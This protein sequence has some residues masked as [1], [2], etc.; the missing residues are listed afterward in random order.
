MGLINLCFEVEDTG[1][2]IPEEQLGHIFEEFEQVDSSRNRQF[3][4]TGLGLAI[5]TR[6]TA[7]MNGRIS[8]TSKLQQGSTFTISI[9]LPESQTKP[10][11]VE[12]SE[13]NLTGLRVLVVDDLE[14]NRRVLSERLC[15]WDVD[16]SLASSGADALTVL[17]AAESPFDLIIQDYQMPHMDGEELAKRIR[18][19]EGSRDTPLIILS[20]VDQ[21]IDNATRTEIGA[22]RLL[23]KPVRAQQ[24]RNTIT[25]SILTRPLDSDEPKAVA[26][27]NVPVE[28]ISVLVA[29]DNK[30]NQLIVKSMLKSASV[31]LTF[32]ENGL[33]ALKKFNEV[34]PNL[35][36]M[37]MSMPEMD[38][39]EATH[40][41]RDLESDN[42]IGHCPIVALTAN[43]M[44]EDQ[45]R[46]LGAGMDD[47][48]SKPI[49][50]K[51]L[52]DAVHRWG[53]QVSD[54]R[55]A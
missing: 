16:V 19:M 51:A 38:G 17:S 31:S 54:R 53:A 52:M 5:S 18:A 7:L 42:A 35:V 21:S 12:D 9:P 47:F 44:Q 24:L 41:I 50:K 13:A 11:Q 30:T 10:L 37:D 15:S 55:T 1:I 26:L 28:Q 29:E 8:A 49:N 46:C 45:D 25:Q 43:A 34:K 2:G 32:A 39:I 23:L 20:S 48:L 6:L 33:E 22:C 14:L 4:G 27:Q 3:E 36:L 40:A